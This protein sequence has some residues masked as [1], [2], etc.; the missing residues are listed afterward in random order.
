MLIHSLLH[1]LSTVHAGIV[2]NY[3]NLVLCQFAVVI[4]SQTVS[5]M[6]GIHYL[7]LS[8]RRVP[9]QVLNA[10]CSLQIFHLIE[11]YVCVYVQCFTCAY[12]SLLLGAPVRAGFPA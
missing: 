5:L 1:I 2:P 12:C 9:L 10:D 6:L 4:S 11:L 7:L 3:T 8:F